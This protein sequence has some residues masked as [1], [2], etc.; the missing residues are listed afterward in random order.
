MVV[1]IQG[2]VLNS[3]DQLKSAVLAAFRAAHFITREYAPHVYFT[4]Y[5][6]PKD[7]Y[8]PAGPL[9]KNNPDTGQFQM[10]YPQEED[11]CRTFPYEH[12]LI[13]S[14]GQYSRRSNDG[15][16]VWNFWKNYV[17]CEE[18]GQKLLFEIGG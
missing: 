15:S 17:C 3:K 7:G 2:M 18:R 11:S 12:N 4:I 6:A 16:Y 5:R 1:F 13:P 9:D 10:L 8:W 14:D